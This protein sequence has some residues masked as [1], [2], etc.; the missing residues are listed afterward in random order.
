MSD[1]IA[2]FPWA[3]QLQRLQQHDPALAPLALFDADGDLD[4]RGLA[5]EQLLQAGQALLQR[6]ADVALVADELRR[7]QKFAPPGRPSLQIVQLRRQQSGVQQ[8]QRV[9]KQAFIRQAD[10]FAR[11]MPL[12]VPAK[13]GTRVTVERW[14]RANLG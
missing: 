13:L 4:A 8:A 11:V 12:E 1:F 2:T 3:L 6:E 10:S 7:Y 5:L 9:A 14:L